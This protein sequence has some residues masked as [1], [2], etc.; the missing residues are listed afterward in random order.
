MKYKVVSLVGAGRI[1]SQRLAITYEDDYDLN[2]Y[3]DDGY[4]W[5]IRKR[6]V[7]GRGRDLAKAVSR[8]VGIPAKY[9]TMEFFRF[10]GES[11]DGEEGE[12]LRNW[13]P[14]VMARQEEIEDWAQYYG[15]VRV[16][17]L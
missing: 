6:L 12:W 8:K 14:E 9:L 10:D 11:E 5:S 4:D 1:K 7:H 16:R 3:D 15:F 13:T 2:D 17:A